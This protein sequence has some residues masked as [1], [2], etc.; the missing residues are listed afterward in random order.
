MT[1]TLKREL[2]PLPA[3]DGD[4]GYDWIHALRGTEWWVVTNWGVDGW[5]LGNWPFVVVATCSVL[6]T[7]PYGVAV[8]VEGDVAVRSYGSHAE[9]ITALDRIAEFYWR[10]DGGSGPDDLPDTGPLRREHCGPHGSSV[11]ARKAGLCEVIWADPSRATV[12]VVPG[13]WLIQASWTGEV[14]W[15]WQC[16]EC[17]DGFGP[18]TGREGAEVG[19]RAH[20]HGDDA[21]VTG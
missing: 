10:Q 12:E 2:P 1:T 17:D 21:T 19:A 18:L 3:A 13:V 4:T 16:R 5:D 14:L 15:F 9:R 7:G 20:R 6:P 8:Y 11:K